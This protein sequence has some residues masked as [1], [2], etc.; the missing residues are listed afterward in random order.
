MFQSGL[1]CT[2]LLI[3]R[4]LSPSLKVILSAPG[5]DDGYYNQIQ[6]MVNLVQTRKMELTNNVFTVNLQTILNFFGRV[7]SYTVLMIQYF[8]MHVFSE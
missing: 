8:Y 6:T 2:M 7:V 3:C 1:I 5:Q 4:Y